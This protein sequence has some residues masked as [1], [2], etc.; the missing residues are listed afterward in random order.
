MIQRKV[1]TGRKWR[2]RAL[3]L[4]L[5]AGLVLQSWSALPGTVEA[6]GT[7][8]YKGQDIISAGAILKKYDW[9]STRKG[10]STKVKVNV[11]E[12]A[13]QNPH[14]RLD[15]MTGQNDKFTT[16]QT[17]KGMANE[18]G[19]IAGVNGD[20]YNTKAS[21]APMGPQ[22][23]NSEIRATPNELPGF[24]SFGITQ[25]NK[26]IIDSFTFT[27]SV[28][29]ANGASFYLGGVN[30][31]YY[32]FEPSGQH[33]MIDSIF[34]YTSAW[35][36]SDRANDGV[37]V[38][39]EVMVQDGIIQ[40][41]RVNG[42]FDMAPPEDGYILRASGKGAEFVQANLNIGEPISSEYNIIPR[43]PSKSYQAEDFKMMIGGHTILV[44][45]GKATAI[46]RSGAEPNGFRARTA[47]GFS[48]DE[49]FA[50]LINVEDNSDSSGMSFAELQDVMLQIGVWKGMNLD[51]GGSSQMVARPLGETSVGL[52]GVP[53]SNFQRR[54]VNG[55]GVYTTAPKGEALG[56]TISG[57]N[58]LFLNE[59]GAY[60]ARGYDVYYNPITQLEDPAQWSVNNSKGT[61]ADNVFTPTQ[62]GTSTINVSSG[63]AAASKEV[64]VVERKD[65][66]SLQIQPSSGVLMENEEIHLAVKAM[67][68]DGTERVVP[69]ASFQW[70]VKGFEGEVTGDTLQVSNVDGTEGG[71]IIASYDGFST[72]LD[73]S[74]G[75]EKLWTDFEDSY[76]QVSFSST[77]GVTGEAARV[78]GLL[79]LPAGQ[80]AIQMQVH[81]EGASGTLA[82]Y[83]QFDTNGV[84]LEGE[85]QSMSLNVWGDASNHWLRAEVIDAAGETH[86]VDLAKTIDWNGWKTVSGDF[87]SLNMAYPVTLNR[88]YVADIDQDRETRA[89][90]SVIGFDDISFH[91]KS[92]ASTKPRNKV[93]LT[94]DKP[95][96]TINGETTV[97]DQAP[98]LISGNTLV[99]I[100]FVTEALGGEVVPWNVGDAERKV[101]IFRDG[102]MAEFWLDQLDTAINGQLVTAEVPP[103]LINERTMVPLRILTENFGWK[104]SWDQP[105]LTVTLE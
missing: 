77:D 41:I 91:Y 60:S 58:S 64:N 61:F 27:G 38:P 79:D 31:T 95:Q 8:T 66:A 103:Q 45:N 14:I 4:L 56:L 48:Q 82:A 35:G 87:S 3:G 53:E 50:Y 89:R 86:R 24:Y 96:I 18:T 85:P 6:A 81:F 104:V 92:S 54:V 29:A 23:T 47:V 22:I 97:I 59:P 57:P 83:T 74:L 88:L 78:E 15:V 30:K 28:S 75:T 80:H 2:Q 11:I 10:K 68:K 17:V 21:L 9:T 43:D 98:V 12:V 51:G 102:Q 26:P 13:L 93:S 16:T 34:L 1:Q 94:I 90:E 99:P 32:W 70:E 65:I 71:Q 7:V 40:D 76:P 42:I 100:R 46:S 36:S 25:D 67:L 37:T 33:S 19:A 55:L 44:D 72:I 39:T 84:Q 62:K 101:T 52:V 105:T 69:A 5:A 73:L 63:K 20:F 49:K